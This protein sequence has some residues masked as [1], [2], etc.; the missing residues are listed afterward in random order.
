MFIE[1]M[2]E[3]TIM[4]GCEGIKSMGLTLKQKLACILGLCR[5]FLG[6][7]WLQDVAS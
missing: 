4:D 3:W 5:Y 2:S 1:E 6:S 7:R